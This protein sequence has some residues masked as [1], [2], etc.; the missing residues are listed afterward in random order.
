MREYALARTKPLGGHPLA[1]WLRK[2]VPQLFHGITSEFPTLLWVASPGQ[3]QWASAPW[4]AALD[5]LVTE[6]PQ[7]G[8]YPVY[9]FSRSLDTAYLSLNRGYHCSATGT[10]R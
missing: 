5:P 2:E 3:G 10:G 9:L 4:I 6:T 7:E 8:Y 1:A